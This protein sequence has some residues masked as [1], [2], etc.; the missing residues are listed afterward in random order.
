MIL[1]PPYHNPL[2]VFF[3]NPEVHIRIFLL[4]RPRL[5]VPFGIGHGCTSHEIVG[6]VIFHKLEKIVMVICGL[7]V[8][9]IL[10]YNPYG[11]QGIRSHTAL[12]TSTN[13]VT[14]HP[15][16][17]LLF[18]EV[19]SAQVQGGKTVYRFTG[20]VGA[21]HYQVFQIRIIDRIEGD[22]EGIDRNFKHGV[23][24]SDLF[25]MCINVGSHSA[26]S[27]NIFF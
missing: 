14:A 1:G 5:S 19:F 10:C 2:A 9:Y 11:I 21:C 12:S 25:P 23:I 20:Q 15:F 13:T 17:F 27:F 22:S 18:I 26:Q 7:G 16:H 24:T 8:I 4:G 6:L 3:N